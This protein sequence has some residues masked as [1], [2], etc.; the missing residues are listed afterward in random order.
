MHFDEEPTE[1][2]MV[3]PR[4]TVI[5]FIVTC[6]IVGS[7]TVAVLIQPLLNQISGS[8]IE[9]ITANPSA[10][11][12]RTVDVKGYMYSYNIPGL[13]NPPFNY[14]LD[15][16]PHA[17]NEM[18]VANNGT[19]FTAHAIGVITHVTGG[20]NPHDDEFVLIHGEIRTARWSAYYLN[21]TVGLIGP[22]C[23]FIEANVIIVELGPAAVPW[24]WIVALIIACAIAGYI[25]IK[26]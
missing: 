8:G 17:S 12:N 19:C 2:I 9:H 26:R 25:T 1:K 16:F 4:K 11:V 20:L 5:G 13:V 15:A 7:V 24:I 3:L 21:G 18:V 22:P 23:Y 14:E 6:V 10:W